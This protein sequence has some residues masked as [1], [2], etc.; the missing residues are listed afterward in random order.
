MGNIFSSFICKIH[1]VNIDNSSEGTNE[2]KYKNNNFE[3]FLKKISN[4]KG[5][6][7]A[8][9]TM[10]KNKSITD[11]ESICLL[12]MSRHGLTRNSMSLDFLNL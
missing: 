8:Y 12:P 5:K 3:N 1:P 11:L 2:N 9:K 7:I 4:R 10:I 6:Q